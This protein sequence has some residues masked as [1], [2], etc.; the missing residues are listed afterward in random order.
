MRKIYVFITTIQIVTGF[1]LP[2]WY[3]VL[4]LKKARSKVVHKII[5]DSQPYVCFQS[6]NSTYVFHT[7]ICP[8]QGG[9][10]SK[11]VVVNGSIQCPYHGFQFCNGM[12]CKIPDPSRNKSYFNLTTIMP[13]F[14][15]RI[16]SDTLFVH[17]RA[18]AAVASSDAPPF[19][20]PEENNASFRSVSGVRMI[21][22]DQQLVVENL[23]DMLHISYV[24]S[25][26][27]RS[28]PLPVSV[29][30]ID[31]SETAGRTVF[32]YS[33]NQNTIS[34][35]VGGNATVL[36]ENEFHLPTTTIT[37]VFA[38]KIVKTV[39]TR[40]IPL[41]PDRTL[42]FWK[43]YRNFWIDPN[44]DVFSSIGDSIISYLMEK[45]IDEDAAILEN[46]YPNQTS[47]LECKYDTTIKQFRKKQ[48]A[49]IEKY[50]SDI[51]GTSRADD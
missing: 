19:F 28:T 25:F 2:L 37:R 51:A 45:T 43:L 47:T 1:L 15:T 35:R 24:H 42:L 49:F 29:R 11:G 40:S 14:A 8:H 13:V 7:D 30:Y 9:S 4:T 34:S 48:A 44:S 23:L 10:L 3:P 46:V 39:M 5:L 16:E 20:P 17:G 26:G 32:R 22:K 33:A 18:A 38:G 12:Y 50:L 41:G 36:V 21:R 31:L 27:S 6:K